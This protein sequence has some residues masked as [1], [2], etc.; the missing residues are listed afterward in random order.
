MVTWSSTV[1]RSITLAQTVQSEPMTEST[2]CEPAAI[3]VRSPI[4]VVPRRMTFGSR[5]TS[6]ASATPWSR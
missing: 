6:S 1:D 3:R 4:R 5:T 2:I